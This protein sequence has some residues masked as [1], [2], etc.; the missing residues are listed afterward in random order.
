MT[1]FTLKTLHPAKMFYNKAV[2]QREIPVIT[3]F[4]HCGLLT[5]CF[6]IFEKGDS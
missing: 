4:L 5:D 1:Q 6:K 3:G 2:T